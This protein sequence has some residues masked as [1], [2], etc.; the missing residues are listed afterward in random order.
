MASAS[1]RENVRLLGRL[2]GAGSAVGL[3]DGE[4][5]E[6]FALRRDDAAEAA[7]ETLL[8]RHGAMVLTTC[9]Q[10]LGD[11]HAAEDAF[12]A[13]FLVVVR[14]AGS[15]RVRKPGS[16]GPWLH[17]VAY[18]I[19]LKARQSTARRRAREHRAAAPALERSAVALEDRE[20]RALLHEEVDRLPAKYR[21]PVVLCYFEG[22]THDEAA[23]AL[24]WPVGTVRGRL[25]RARDRIRDGLARR[26]MSPGGSIESSLMAPAFRGEPSAPLLEA[27]V[28][29]AIKGMPAAA[30]GAMAN[31]ML[32]GLLMARFKLTAD[33]LT[34]VLMTAGFGLALRGAPA[35]QARRRPEPAT[36][37]VATDRARS[38]R[39][40]RHGDPLPEHARARLGTIPFRDGTLVNQ[41]FYTS[42]AKSLV[43][44]NNTHVVRVWNATTGRIVREIGDSKSDFHGIALSPDGNTLVTVEKP[45]RL[46]LWDVASGRERRQWHQARGEEYDHPVFSPNG[47]TVAV[48]VHRFDEATRKSE[49]F[50]DLWDTTALTEHRRR[51]PGDWARLW[52]LKFSPDGTMLATASRDTEIYEG[53]T[54][55]G[56]DKGSTRLWDL[57]TG[58]ERRRFLVDRLD[59]NS[60]A[61]SPDGRLL[62]V[63]VSDATVRLYDLS[64]GQERMPRLGTE[65]ARPMRGD[66]KAVPIRPSAI[67]RLA[68][69]PDG[70]ILAGGEARDSDD[71]SLAAIHLWDVARGH[72]LHRIPAHQQRVAALSFSPDGKALASTGAEPV[73]RLWDVATGH[74]A[75]AQPGHRSAVRSLTISPADGTVFTGG[76]D[77]TIRRWDP[78][79]GRELGKIA[80]LGGPVQT[81]AVA[82]DGKTLL[83]VGPMHANPPPAGWISLWSVTEHREIRRLAHIRDQLAWQY[84]AYSPDRKSVA[85]EG[86]IWDAIS[87]E[88]LVTLRHQDPQNDR[89]FGFCPIYYTPDGKRIITAEPD[90][91]RIWDIAT[92]REVRRAVVWS[93]CHDRATLSP[94]GRFLA[95]RGPGEHSRGNSVDWP[96]RIWELASGNEVAT[97]EAQ[98]DLYIRRP[99]SPDGRFLASAGGDSTV[100]VRDLATGRVMRRFEG[101]LGPVS[102]IAFAPDGR[103][104]ISASE[105]ATALV[106]DLSDLTG[107]RA[108]AG[109]IENQH[110]KSALDGPSRRPEA[111]GVEP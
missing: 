79:S 46:R 16:L 41:V 8:A 105:D 6:R 38:T 26:G 1:A 19:A 66:I 86:Q 102:A 9:R 13:T 81:L 87:G 49:S 108:N 33:M 42:D 44:V 24:Q 36:A 40:D 29:V 77:G 63:A 61:F 82:P 80:Q 78:S 15:L 71:F 52:D 75:F 72:E 92:G 17:G 99:F 60:L 37:R 73:I 7:F 69:S 93:N 14:R 45:G 90:G 67:G 103:R 22:R 57:A 64:T 74:E 21:A 104:V 98:G 43:T 18:R 70:T 55:I 12:Q 85:S 34:I 27:T 110:A 100:R 28:A 84:V 39:L 95:T 109:A 11:S 3:T 96:Y 65:L 68:F 5:L 32:R 20:L 88:V 89:F 91:V 56:A 107:Q 97:F 35:S 59:A 30:V 4:L 2:F 106:W 94:D 47:R 83:V 58:R 50:I 23:A 51:I 54:L 76:D 53:N 62:A 101:H 31:L 48:S 10:V 25:A 111:Q